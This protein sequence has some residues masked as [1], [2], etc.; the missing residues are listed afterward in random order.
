MTPALSE[1]ATAD[2]IISAL[3]EN[4][5]EYIRTFKLANYVEFYDEPDLLWFITGIPAP[6]FNAVQHTRLTED[7]IDNV[8]R[9]TVAH[10]ANRKVPLGWLAGPTSE[11]ASLEKHLQLQGFKMVAQIPG[12]AVDIQK[13]IRPTSQVAGL[14]I[15]RVADETTL[16]RWSEAEIQCFEE[17]DKIASGL[18]TLR[19]TIGIGSEVNLYHYLAELDDKAVATA[20][21]LLG[22]GVAGIYDV[23]TLPEMRRRGIAANLVAEVLGEAQKFGYRIGTLQSS[24]MGKRVYESLGFKEYCIYKAY[25]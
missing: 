21:L 18:K 15:K 9:R 12:M 1:N 25:E 7:R 3:A 14:S 17:T 16:Q 10:F 11:P 20:T 6:S 24:Q 19:N 22:G 13:A 5:R 4:W 23:A 8:I 2:E